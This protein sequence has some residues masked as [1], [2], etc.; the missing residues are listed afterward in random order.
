MNPRFIIV[1]DDPTNNLLCRLT[2][3]KFIGKSDIRCFES[4]TEGL[5]FIS[6]EYSDS[7]KWVE[8][9]LFL[10]IN[11]PVMDGWEFLDEFA[12]LEEYIHK[13]FAIYI[14]SSSSDPAEKTKAARNIYVKGFIEKPLKQEI[15]TELLESYA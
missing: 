13:Q 4:S 6:L 11:M 15:V 8:T 10:D 7:S 3:T 12:K 9:I 5:K 2:L 1:N 14:F